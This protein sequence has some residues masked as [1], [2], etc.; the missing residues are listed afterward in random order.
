MSSD[1]DI[2]T[3]Q[4]FNKQAHE[5]LTKM[6]GNNITR[7]NTNSN[8]AFD[9]VDYVIYELETL[10]KYKYNNEPYFIIIIAAGCASRA[11]A[12]VIY[13]R[14]FNINP[15]FVSYL[16]LIT[17]SYSTLLSMLYSSFNM[18]HL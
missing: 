13:S 8:N 9:Q 3:I 12:S 6:F 4:Q 10:L 2:Q 11:F 15:N 1:I 5:F 7:I 17:Q 16:I 18:L 14:F